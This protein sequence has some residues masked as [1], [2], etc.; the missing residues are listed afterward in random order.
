MVPQ[1]PMS[2]TLFSCDDQCEFIPCMYLRFFAA[3]F[4]EPGFVHQ[5]R[6]DLLAL[7]RHGRSDWC[8][9][10]LYGNTRTLLIEPAMVHFKIRIG[11]VARICRS[12]SSKDD[13]FRQGRGSIP[14]FGII[15]FAFCL[16]CPCYMRQGRRFP[17]LPVLTLLITPAAFVGK[18][19]HLLV[20]STL[21]Y[22]EALVPECC[23]QV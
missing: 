20:S 19:L 18:V 6:S 10:F 2:I 5:H 13:Q 23:V 16:P 4:R 1:Q 11:L 15:S 12:Q 8:F 7:S 22:K 17:I 14:R 3:R 9:H 21:L